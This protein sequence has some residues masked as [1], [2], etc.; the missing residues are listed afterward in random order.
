[1]D[2]VRGEGYYVVVPKILTPPLEGGTDGD[3][4]PA[5]FDMAVRGAEIRPFIISYPWAMLAPRVNAVL[6]YMLSEGISK[7]ALFGVCWG[8]WVSSQILADENMPP[9]VICSV[10]PHP[11]ITCEEMHG[12]DAVKLVS[13]AKGPMLL[14][15][16]GNDPDRYRPGG[17]MFEA[18]RAAQPDSDVSLDFGAMKHGWSTRGDVSDPATR[19]AV[20]LALSKAITYI[21]AQFAKRP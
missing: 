6:K 19:A 3:G 15:P 10:I 9:Q 12:G 2:G 5:N 8:G 7:I 14:L 16:A 1:L 20:D 4:L 17:D 18:L 21:S 13:R 11:S